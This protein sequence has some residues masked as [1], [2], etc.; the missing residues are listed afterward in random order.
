MSEAKQNIGTCLCGAVEVLPTQASTHVSACHC[1]MCRKWS[2]GPLVVVDCNGEVN[3]SG[4]NNVGIY[5]SSEWAERGFCKQC[6]SHLFFRLKG[7]THYW[8]P[9]GLFADDKD[10]SFDLQVFIEE[11]PDYY[12]FL[13]ETRKMTGEEVVAEFS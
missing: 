13:N 1:K 12:D 3:F 5:D 10:F 9:A 7:G 11:K 4:E 6:G 8:I 2:G